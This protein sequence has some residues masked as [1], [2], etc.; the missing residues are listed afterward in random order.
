MR[1]P[2][3]GRIALL[4]GL[5]G[6]VLLTQGCSRLRVHAEPTPGVDYRPLATWSWSAGMQ[7]ALDE[8][9]GEFPLRDAI[10]AGLAR[11]GYRH[12][13]DEAAAPDFRVSFRVRTNVLTQQHVVGDV[14]HAV[15]DW[16]SPAGG[17]VW[18]DEHRNVLL[19]VIFYEP[20]GGRQI[21]QGFASQR[22]P[23]D[24][25]TE[26]RRLVAE[27]LVSAILKRFPS[28]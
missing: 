26:E 19:R 10:E 23:A 15:E 7:R 13:Q 6:L 22:L 8:S 28:R 9:T 21:W 27:R 20:E 16:F 1:A 3:C 14:P 17:S 4:A 5:A 11:R 2:A 18:I 12:L 24:I 25:P